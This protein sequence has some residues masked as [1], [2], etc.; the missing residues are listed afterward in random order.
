M[1]TPPSSAF[2]RASALSRSFLLVHRP[3]MPMALR[4]QAA[5]LGGALFGGLRV[6]VENGDIGAR[7]SDT[8][9]PFHPQKRRRRRSRPRPGRQ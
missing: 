8:P 4:P 9:W 2:M 6:D 7:A 3:L 5:N 1:L